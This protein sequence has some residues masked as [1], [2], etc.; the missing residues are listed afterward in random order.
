MAKVYVG[1]L[2][3]GIPEADVEHEFGRFGRL[4]SVWVARK[5]PGF[6]EHP[7]K[8]LLL[9]LRSDALHPATSVDAA[10]TAPAAHC[11]HTTVHLRQTYAC[12][13]VAV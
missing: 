6:G 11:P 8:R 13:V 2:P 3:P 5:P 7:G 12:F 10:A 1:N 9:C 4:R